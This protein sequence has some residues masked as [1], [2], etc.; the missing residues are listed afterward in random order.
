MN[1]ILRAGL[2]SM[3]AAV[4]AVAL[5]PMAVVAKAA[6]EIWQWLMPDEDRVPQYALGANT[7]TNLIPA[8]YAG[9]N[10]VSREMVGFI[11]AFTRNSTADRAAVGQQVLVPIAEVGDAE[12][13]T[14]GQNPANTGDANIGNAPV[15]ITKAKAVPIRWNGEETLGMTNAGTYDQVIADQFAEAIRKLV[16]LVEIDCAVAAKIASSRAYGTAGTP[17]F[18]T[19]G[20]MSDLAQVMKILDDNG[21]PSGRQLVVNSTSMANLRGKMSNLFKADE[22]GTDEL[23]RTGLLT[24]PLQG[25]QLRYSGG[26][27]TH[28]KG[29]GT[30]YL[31]NNASGIAVGGTTIAADTGANTILAGDVVTFA[32]DTGN[33]Y[34]VGTA[35]AAGSFAINKPGARVAIPDNNAITVGN[36]YL[37][38]MVFSRNAFV[39]ATR[40]PA[41]PRA[42][43]AAID[44]MMLT[45]PISGLTFE[46][47]VYAQYRQVKYEV[48]LAWGVNGVKPEHSALLLG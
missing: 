16:N 37:P 33:K 11:S 12:D 32:A 25:A 14:P 46:V 30:G 29:T 5:Y 43:D 34:I 3:V 38:N 28:T 17:P 23:L 48:C 13:I 21:A 24:V 26:I 20:D 10:I 6:A 7:L 8:M 31:V 15:V 44:S 35:L 47:R 45:D 39:L 41:L 18:A 40:A 2:I 27:Q 4:A 9:L 19:A 42:G 36:S 1:R 22:A